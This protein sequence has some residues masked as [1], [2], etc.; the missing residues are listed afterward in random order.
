ML[1]Q[2]LIVPNELVLVIENLEPISKAH[3]EPV[4]PT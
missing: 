2:F 4:F 1:M 3:V